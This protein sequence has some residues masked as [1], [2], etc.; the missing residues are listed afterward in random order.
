MGQLRQAGWVGIWLIG[1]AVIE[2]VLVRRLPSG[3]M[4]LVLL[5]VVTWALLRGPE[6]GAG[7]GLAGG[8]LQDLL[9]GHALGLLAGPKILVGFLCGMW[10]D[11]VQPGGAGI[12]ALAAL[13]A[14]LV[15]ILASWGV[16]ALVGWPVGWVRPG[17]ILLLAC[18]HA[19]MAPLVY[20]AVRRG[21]GVGR[22]G[23]AASR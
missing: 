5:V 7:V 4:D 1:A 19:A 3:R 10:R 6:A 20:W 23:R 18:S 15:D 16:R 17:E 14:F 9:S 11:V 8:L 2:P 12:P 22:V 21:P 13:G